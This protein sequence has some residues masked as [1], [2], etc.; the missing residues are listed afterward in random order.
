[1]R[2]SAGQSHA[3]RLQLGFG[4][5]PFEKKQKLA[6]DRSFLGHKINIGYGNKLSL[7]SLSFDLDG[8]ALSLATA[9]TWN[10]ALI[11]AR[12][13]KLVE[14]VIRANLLPGESIV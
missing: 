4:R 1:M 5:S 11:K 6:K 8:Q 2:A 12:T 13:E 9:P 7:N 3:Q 14:M 10:E